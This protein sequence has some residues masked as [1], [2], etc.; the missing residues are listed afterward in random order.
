MGYRVHGVEGFIKVCPTVV[1]TVE[2][3]LTGGATGWGQG[4]TTT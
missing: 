4:A 2:V 3:V 1:Q